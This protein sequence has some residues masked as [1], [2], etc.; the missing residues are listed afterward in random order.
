MPLNKVS[1]TILLKEKSASVYSVAVDSTIAA[2]VA[3]M[4]N[5]RVGSVMVKNTERVVGIFTERDVLTRVVAAGRDPNTTSVRE[6][7][8]EQFKFITPETSVEDAMQVMTEK[9]VRH[10]PVMDGEALI[11]LL[12]I[13]DMTRWL[14]KVN[15]MEAENL[16][17]YVFSDYPG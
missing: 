6:V 12:S 2:A 16:R 13:G 1:V 7:M 10:L 17:R 3:E 11:G 15:E 14:L 9:R 4:N 8:T 5:H